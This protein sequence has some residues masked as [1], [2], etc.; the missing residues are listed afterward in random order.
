MKFNERVGRL[1]NKLGNSRYLLNTIPDTPIK[2]GRETVPEYSDGLDS[3][4]GQFDQVIQPEF[5]VAW[6]G[7]L[8]ALAAYNHDVG[9][10]VD[11]IVSLANTDYTIEFDESVSEETQKQLMEHLHNKVDTWYNYADGIN[12]MN[13]DFFT[14]LA[15][16]GA[17]S[18][19][20][21]VANDLSGIDQVVRV[22]PKNIRFLFDKE[23]ECFIPV[24][25]KGL[26][27]LRTTNASGYVELNPTTYRYIA[28]RRF[29]E[30][31]YALPLFL[32]AI[33][34]IGIQRDMIGNMA[35]V[36]KKLGMLGFM[37]VLMDVPKR[38]Q[39]ETEAQYNTRVTT[40]LSKGAEEAA[41][42]MA[43]GLV[44]GFKDQHE[45]KHNEVK[46]DAKGASDLY[47]MNENNVMAGLKQAP[48]ML[49]RQQSI[50]ETFGRVLLAKF[51]AQVDNFQKAYGSFLKDGFNLEAK[52][53]GFAVDNIIRD[54]VFE[55]PMLG[56]AVREQDAISKKIENLDSLYKQGVIS[57]ETRAQRLGEEAPD[58]EEPRTVMEEREKEERDREND[59]NNPDNPSNDEDVTKSKATEKQALKAFE[60]ADDEGKKALIEQ[61]GDLLGGS[62][63][64]QFND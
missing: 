39:N 64:E 44:V 54:V 4:T 40:H 48:E 11:N 13:N 15:V 31:P 33:Q 23:N 63:P 8:E 53:A 28:M 52:L 1:L 41:K 60:G 59:S 2:G 6:L 55:K 18:G 24:Q 45:F 37:E 38:A 14:Q 36:M 29:G 58:Q 26:L 3:L 32:T 22:N 47:N 35:F 7:V 21:V 30:S 46:G 10:A 34:S 20:F 5:N 61:Y 27:G 43:N 25:E 51:S 42:G 56:D 62:L 16:T 17:I 9:Y 50:S 12:S 57:Q 49:G 19:E